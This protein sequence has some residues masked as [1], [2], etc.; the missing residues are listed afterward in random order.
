MGFKFEK[1]RVWHLALE[2]AD[3]AEIIAR[4]FPGY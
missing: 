1:L 3:D 2:L 4:K